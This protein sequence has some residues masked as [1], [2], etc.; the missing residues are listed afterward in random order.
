MDRLFTPHDAASELD[1]AV[2]DYLV[3]IHVSLRPTARLPDAQRKVS[4][5]IAFD[6]FVAGLDDEAGF[7]RRQLSEFLVYLRGSF[8]ENAKRANH[9]AGHAIA[10]NVE[11]VERA[12][13]LRS[14]VTVGR[15]LDGSHRVGFDSSFGGLFRGILRH[16]RLNNIIPVGE[17]P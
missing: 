11:V 7:I 16:W 10:A 15:Y 5:E 12:F 4:V 1:R 14:P 3:G 17:I 13:G 6:D 9:L 8:F 2:R